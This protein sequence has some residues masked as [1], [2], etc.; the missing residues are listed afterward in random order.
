MKT[1]ITSDENICEYKMIE[2]TKE[3]IKEG[4]DVYINDLIKRILKLESPNVHII[5]RIKYITE[6][7]IKI[8]MDI[9]K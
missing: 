1:Y 5:T 8:Y 3:N 4:L 2:V 7:N 9:R 6:K